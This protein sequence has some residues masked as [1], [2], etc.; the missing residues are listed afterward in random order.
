[1]TKRGYMPTQNDAL[2]EKL[3]R[4][5]EIDIT[6]TGRKVGRAISNPIWFV[7]DEISSTSCR[8]RIGHAVV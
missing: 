2:G 4:S 3:S 1:M 7:F 5:S 6:V 8:C